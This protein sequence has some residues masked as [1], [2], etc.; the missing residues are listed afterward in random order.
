[1][2]RLG[3]R[4]NWVGVLM[5]VKAK[6]AHIV[7]PKKMLT[8]SSSATLSSPAETLVSA[9]SRS[10]IAVALS[11][12]AFT[13]ERASISSHTCSAAVSV[14]TAVSSTAAGG[15]AAAPSE[16][17]GVDSMVCAGAFLSR[18][19]K[20]LAP[21]QCGDR[22]TRRPIRRISSCWR[23]VAAGAVAGREDPML[24]KKNGHRG[25]CGD[26]EIERRGSTSA[27]SPPFCSDSVMHR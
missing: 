2:C 9:S 6:M 20:S 24:P 5:P 21:T 18:R 1:M 11:S 12:L 26:G 15:G 19:L 10:A 7:Y 14:A 4:E 8:C 25:E 16:L 17:S 22:T 27:G 23:R 13:S 3:I